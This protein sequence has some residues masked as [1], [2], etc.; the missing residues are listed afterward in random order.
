MRLL[1]TGTLE[2]QNFIGEELPHYAILSHTWQ[3][4][5][6]VYN[7]LLRGDWKSKASFKKISGFCSLANSSGYTWCWIDTLCIDQSSSAELSEAINSMFRWYSQAQVC[8]A[9]LADVRIDH[10]APVQQELEQFERSRW[11]TR[12]WTLQ[13]LITPRSVE[14]YDEDWLQIGTRLVL[15]E[16][17]SRVTGIH[18]E[19]LG[20]CSDA[21][22]SLKDYC[23]AERMSWAAGRV[24]SRAEDLAY[25]LLGI[26]DINMPLLYGEG[27]RA[28][29]RLQLRILAESEDFTLFAWKGRLVSDADKTPQTLLARSA[30]DFGELRVTQDTK[31]RAWSYSSLDIGSCF[32]VH[33][34][35]LI[36][37]SQYRIKISRADDYVPEQPAKRLDMIALSMAVVPKFYQ[38]PAY[39]ILCKMR[40]SKTQILCLPVKTHS[41]PQ[42]YSKLGSPVMIDLALLENNTIHFERASVLLNTKPNKD[43]RRQQSSLETSTIFVSVQN[44]GHT[45]KHSF[46]HS[47]I[48]CTALCLT[49]DYN[50][51]IILQGCEP[52]SNA[53]AKS[54]HWTS[55]T[56]YDETLPTEAD[57]E[58]TIDLKFGDYA[59]KLLP[60]GVH[61]YSTLKRRSREWYCSQQATID[62]TGSIKSA[63]N[64][65][66]NILA[67][68]V[69]AILPD[70]RP[71][72]LKL[73]DLNSHFEDRSALERWLRSKKADGMATKGPV[74]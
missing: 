21:S 58:K 66:G 14:F 22:L 33:T 20:R 24:T 62:T 17:L 11:H 45:I 18:T 48:S 49:Q 34:E 9:Y 57:E 4:D 32:K 28:F 61:I 55:I 39:M 63:T 1:N 73:L 29:E 65:C 53:K 36:L 30:S 25:C 6:A 70:G 51:I 10:T 41:R 40:N 64:L 19:L 43:R 59:H 68:D 47:G 50:N 5:E 54:A 69:K 23:V 12:G 56:T 3:P 67:L 16:S 31:E 42:T 74:V 26:F 7:D 72:D 46:V 44:G 27:H 52:G 15:S 35:L 2:L 8:Y 71:G 38:S 13:E 60:N 37:Y